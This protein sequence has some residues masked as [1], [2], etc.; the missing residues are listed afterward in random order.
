M[1]IQLTGEQRTVVENL[2]AAGRFSSV[3]EAVL[4]GVR[5]LA[6][7]ER[8]RSQVQMGI[9][10]AERGDGH[11]HD[12]VFEQLKRMAFEAEASNG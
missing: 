8:L 11:D 1:E 7:N 5:L 3:E 2:V 12:T 10:Q 4:E 9:D 6:A